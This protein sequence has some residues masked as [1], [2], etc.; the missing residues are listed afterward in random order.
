MPKYDVVIIGSGLGGLLCG[1]ILSK[2]GKSVCILEK[3]HQ[4]GGNLQTFKRDGK[5]F[6][7]GFHYVGGLNEGQNLYQYFKY[8]GLIDKLKLERLDLNCFDKIEFK[9]NEYSFAQGF[10]NFVETL[11][12]DFPSEKNALIDYK[13]KI[14]EVCNHFPLYNIKSVYDISSEQKYL[15]QS[16]GSFLNSI[17]SNKTLQNV[18][19]GNNLLYAGISNKSSLAMHALISNSFI[20]GGA[21]RFV[22]GSSQIADQ[23]LKTIEQN[24]GTLKK[25]SEVINFSFKN[26]K[27]QSVLLMKG[28]HIEGNQF[29]STIHPYSTLKMIDSKL[30]RKSYRERI[31]ELEETISSFILFVSLKPNSFK[32]LKSNYYHHNNNSVWTISDYDSEK[33]PQNY[34]FLTPPSSKSNEFADTAIVLAY[35]KYE[36]VKQWEN[37]KTGNRGAEYEEFK[38]LKAEKLIDQVEQKHKGFKN[39]IQKYYTSTPITYRDYTGTRDGSLYGIVHD[40]NHLLKTTILAK[41]KIPNLLLSGQNI[42]LHGALGVTVSS[43]IT[44][45][46]ILG[47]D[48]LIQKINHA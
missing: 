15:E 30:I 48:Y 25:N 27:I 5:I 46:E 28:E 37:T 23:L 34:M 35:M 22:D 45:S 9:S 19:A 20:E 44:C 32:Y 16:I 6:D 13:N 7:T 38:K 39:S 47:M 21:Y 14:K 33:W 12:N 43:V 11:A 3:H 36:E 24:G 31:N 4:F 42:N 2:E 1:T 26:D 40:C 29:I 17:T 18:L 41:T 10:N 8:F